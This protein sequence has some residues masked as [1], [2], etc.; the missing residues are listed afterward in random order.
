[1]TTRPR[2][3]RI[4]GTRGIPNRHGGFEAWAQHLAPW[5]VERGWEVTVYCQEDPG[6][7]FRQDTWR[8]VTLEHVPA[9]STGARG[10]L[11][12]D[13]WTARHAARH[14]DLLLTLGFNTA[15]L[16]PWY[17]LRGRRH[18]VNMD[19]VEWRRG[20]W[21]LP[22]RGWFW[23]NSWVAGYAANHL[24]ADHPGIADMLAARGWSRRT[25]MVPYGA[26][27]V[28]TA[29]ADALAAFDL[30]PRRYGLV[31]ARPEAGELDPRDR[32]GLVRT[33]RTYPLVVLGAYAGRHRYH[34]AVRAA[35]GPGVRFPGAPS[36]DTAIVQALRHHAR[37]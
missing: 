7:G 14:D 2:R 18:V 9:P 6:S 34:A 27:H 10:S 4:L 5:L 26:D 20:K 22:V 13:A 37:L 12:F 29:P 16:F 32:A 3:L 8:G 17:R 11:W 31:I 21:S 30:E 35:A 28:E 1:M 23:V 36:Y 24:I 33:S 15:V 25:T 19:G